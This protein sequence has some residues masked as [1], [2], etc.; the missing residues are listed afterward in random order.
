MFAKGICPLNEK[1]YIF[2]K[3]W[4]MSKNMPKNLQNNLV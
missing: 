1:I 4:T 2:E 3:Q